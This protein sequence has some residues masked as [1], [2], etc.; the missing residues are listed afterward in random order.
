MPSA[1]CVGSKAKEEA[2]R[3]L[4]AHTRVLTGAGVQGP[5][6]GSQQRSRDGT[7]PLTKSMSVTKSI[8]HLL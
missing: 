2:E 6:A 3:S 8:I 7:V 1:G 4:A 5:A